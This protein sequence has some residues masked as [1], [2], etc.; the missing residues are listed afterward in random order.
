MTRREAIVAV[1]GVMGVMHGSPFVDPLHAGQ[2]AL[3]L[4]L[5]GI[6]GIVVQYRG[7]RVLLSPEDIM[8]ALAG[9]E[10]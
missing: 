10:A 8:R 9:K 2:R 7:Q 1:A 4:P 5:D 6:E 3:T